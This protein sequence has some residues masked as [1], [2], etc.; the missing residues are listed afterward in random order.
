MIKEYET[1]IGAQMN[2]SIKDTKTNKIGKVVGTGQSGN[3]DIIYVDFGRGR[4]RIVPMDDAQ[5]EGRYHLLK[6]ED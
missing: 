2:D 1:A 6:E 5:V 3:Y 4:R